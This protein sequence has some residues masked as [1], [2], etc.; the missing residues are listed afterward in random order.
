MIISGIATVPLRIP[1]K[2]GR[3]SAASV[4]GPAGSPAV[5]S[6]LVK[7]TTDEGCEGWGE[8][9]GFLG[10]PVTQRAIDDLIAPL[11]IGKDAERVAPLMHEVQVKLQVF[12]G[13][14]TL[15]LSAVDI[16]PWDVVG[17]AAGVP[18]HRLLGG[19][20]ADLPCRLNGDLLAF[21]HA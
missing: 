10:V 21:T 16:A 5:D 13:P 7:V 12:R 18:L 8:A 11:C 19:G 1:Y 15:A 9:F 4:W 14:L 20:A 2:P 17:K 3:E 6:L